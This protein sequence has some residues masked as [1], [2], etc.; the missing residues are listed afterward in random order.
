MA[1]LYYNLILLG[2]LTIEEVPERWNAEV[3]ALINSQ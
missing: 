3:Q 2:R 1:R